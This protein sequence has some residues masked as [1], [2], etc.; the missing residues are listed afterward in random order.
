MAADAPHSI[1]ISD[2][3]NGFFAGG[4]AAAQ[5]GGVADPTPRRESRFGAEPSP[6]AAG[7]DD[8]PGVDHIGVVYQPAAPAAIMAAAK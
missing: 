5:T 4:D 6:A 3:Q 8:E 1:M 2:Y 7:A